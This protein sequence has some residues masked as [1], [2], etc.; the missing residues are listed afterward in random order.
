MAK[1]SKLSEMSTGELKNRLSAVRK[2]Q[3][4]IGVI[5]L[6]IILAWVVLGY[7]KTNVPVFIATLCVAVGS[8]TSMVA[9]TASLGAE[10]KKRE[11]EAERSS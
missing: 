8:L 7:W 10:L 6:V 4:T 11:S 9:S 3:I 1:Q 5:F 2:V